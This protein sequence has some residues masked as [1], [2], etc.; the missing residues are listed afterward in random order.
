MGWTSL[1]IEDATWENFQELKDQFANLNLE[2]KVHLEA[3][4]NDRSARW[5]SQTVQRGRP[6]V[7]KRHMVHKQW[8]FQLIQQKETQLLQV[9]RQDS[10]I[11]S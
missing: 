5:S 8:A 3:G 4:G 6:G 1:L 7:C 10:Q 11:V 9:I 2:D